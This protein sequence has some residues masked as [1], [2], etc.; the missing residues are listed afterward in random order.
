M[1][2]CR[3]VMT[4]GLVSTLLGPVRADEI[5]FTVGWLHEYF[6]EFRGDY[7]RSGRVWEQTEETLIGRYPDMQ[8]PSGEYLISGCRPHSCTEK[9]AVVLSPSGNPIVVGLINSH[10]SE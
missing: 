6:A 4:V 5:A 10:C 7:I 9:A 2:L 1:L 8:L 3:A